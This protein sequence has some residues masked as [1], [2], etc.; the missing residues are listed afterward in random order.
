MVRSVSHPKLGA[1]DLVGQPVRFSDCDAGPRTAA[2][3]FGEH[4]DV[5]LRELGYD[6]RQIEEL[7]Q[8]NIIAAGRNA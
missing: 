8:H 4:T 3:E 1:L 6:A 7:K 2:P 5:I